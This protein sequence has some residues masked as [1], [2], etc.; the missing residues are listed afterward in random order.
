MIGRTAIMATAYKYGDACWVLCPLPRQPFYL[1]QTSNGPKQ[2]S[3]HVWQKAKFKRWCWCWPWS[4]KF[5]CR[6]ALLDYVGFETEELVVNAADLRLRDP[7]RLGADIPT[8]YAVT[9][10]E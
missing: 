4:K 9:R 2:Y 6:V 8:P 1:Q 7:Y 3:Y 10:I 5:L